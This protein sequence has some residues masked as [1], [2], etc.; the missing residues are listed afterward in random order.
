MW[1]L[2]SLSRP[3]RIRQ[4]VD[5]YDWST[6][7]VALV[8]Y[9]GDPRLNE[10][11]AKKWPASW[12]I[13]MVSMRGNGPTYNEMLRRYPDEWCY[14]FLADDAVLN[15]PGML[16]DLEIAADDWNIA[17]ANDGHW[18]GKLPT[19]PC[20]GGD[21]VRAVGYL[22]PEYLNHWAIDT[23]WGEIGKRLGNLRYFD[24]LTY[25]HN[26]PVWG[27]APDDATYQSARRASADW[28]DILR[29]WMVN[30]MLSAVGRVKAARIKAA[31]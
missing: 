26:N 27:T 25:A 23:A 16:S 31:A 29:S 4:L 5:S 7:P 6:Q 17:Y 8:L 2:T 11:L 19:M 1:L 15:V 12:D 13:H 9:D 18:G 20:L 21:L 14:G 22:A 24:Q 28:Q 30:D 3:E 10:Y